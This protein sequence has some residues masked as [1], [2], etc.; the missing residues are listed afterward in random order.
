MRW[1][2]L[3][4]ASV[5]LWAVV[6]VSAASPASVRGVGTA[7]GARG[8]VGDFLIGSV[9]ACSEASPPLQSAIAGISRRSSC[10]AAMADIRRKI[11]ADS[12]TVEKNVLKEAHTGAQ[13]A[14]SEHFTESGSNAWF[15]KR[16][17]LAALV[18]AMRANEP[19][20][21]VKVGRGPRAARGTSATTIVVDT[22]QSR[23]TN[24]VLHG[25][26]AGG[27]IWTLAAS[28]AGKPHISRSAVAG[29]ASIV[30]PALRVFP[31]AAAADADPTRVVVSFTDVGAEQSTEILVEVGTDGL[32]GTFLIGSAVVAPVVGTGSA[33]T[34]DLATRLVQAYS[35]GGGAERCAFLHPK[36]VAVV[37]AQCSSSRSIPARDVTTDAQRRASADGTS[38][39]ALAV[40][41]GTAVLTVT[42]LVTPG[43]AGVVVTGI[44]VDIAEIAALVGRPI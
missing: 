11:V 16:Y 18:R 1:T 24:L 25:E 43:P 35:T 36:L 41:F 38:V 31:L 20:L 17:P 34:H 22:A 9:N 14:Y 33:D 3:T 32:V 40:G 10:A 4:L 28:P 27:A 21:L 15:G 30:A 5:C 23:P 26:S 44:F 6:A 29:V 19:D 37:G 2:S 42:F 13:T 8:F 12:Q 7:D 39:V